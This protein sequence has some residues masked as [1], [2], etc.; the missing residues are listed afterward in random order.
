MTSE[1]LVIVLGIFF[2]VGVVGPRIS[3]FGE[4][5][6]VEEWPAAIRRRLFLFLPSCLVS[7]LGFPD[8]NADL[9]NFNT[10]RP[11]GRT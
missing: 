9:P 8:S 10:Y 6:A 2:C 11:A 1:L 4:R 7:K 3:N 5:C